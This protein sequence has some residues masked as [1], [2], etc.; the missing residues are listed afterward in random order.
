MSGQI[1]FNIWYWL[2]AI[3]ALAVFQCI[4]PGL[5]P[6]GITPFVARLSKFLCASVRRG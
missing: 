1:R 3:V 2:F 6:I 4:R 5:A